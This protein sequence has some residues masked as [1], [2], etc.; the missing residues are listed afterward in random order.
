M[1]HKF[2]QP[3]CEGI[4]GASESSSPVRKPCARIGLGDKLVAPLARS[5]P[6]RDRHRAATAT[7]ARAEGARAAAVKPQ[8]LPARGAPPGPLPSPVRAAELGMNP[9]RREA[10][11]RPALPPAAPRLPPPPPAGG[12]DALIMMRPLLMRSRRA[13]CATGSRRSAAG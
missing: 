10:A 1:H 7:G 9:V 8:R 4:Q 11:V 3:G 5:E 12:V 6:S 13:G 2:K